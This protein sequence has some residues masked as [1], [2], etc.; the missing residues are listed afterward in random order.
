MNKVTQSEEPSLP[1]S[2]IRVLEM[3]QL[4]AGPFAGQMLAAFGAEV[5]KIEPP[6]RG[7]PLRTW[8]ELDEQGTSYWWRSIARNKKSVTLDLSKPAGCDI[9]RRLLLHCDIL[10]E[11]F[12]PGRMEAWGLG[13]AQIRQSHPDLIYTRVS[14][15]G[16]TGPYASRPGFASACEAVAGLRYVNGYPGEKPVRL[17]LSLGDSLAGLHAIIGSLLA[18]IARQRLG[19][20]GQTIDV[21][22]VESV[23]NM[24]EGVLPE[25]DGA[26]RVREPSGSTV[27]G[28][29]PTN[30]YAC[31]DGRYIVIGGNGDSIFRRLMR[32]VG[33]DDL[34]EDSRL[35]DNRGRVA[36]ESEIDKVLSIWSA[37][38]DSIDALAILDKADVPAGP[39]N[40]IADI[41]ADPHFA[42]RGTFEEITVNGNIRRVPAVHPRLSDTPATTRWA[43]PDLG[44]HTEQVL[45]D[46]LKIDVSEVDNWREQGLI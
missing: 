5:I 13:P 36:H 6:G 28:I 4:I 8:R 21:S 20:S 32:A 25:Y 40:S 19:Q 11:N 7:D 33:R 16:Q 45:M 38:L 9:A 31:L 22:I 15:Y 35:A 2:G 27:T 34:V 44:E 18:L 43:G 39:V 17:N 37:S 12:R 46:Y 42:A 10:I 24:M 3:G 23:F 41:A 29:V 30:T 26:Q 1:L 14:G